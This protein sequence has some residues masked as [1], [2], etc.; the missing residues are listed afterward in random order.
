MKEK[1]REVIARELENRLDFDSFLKNT[2]D[3]LRKLPEILASAV[4]EEIERSKVHGKNC[5]CP[6]CLDVIYDNLVDFNS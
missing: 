5:F 4:A 1:I 6:V 3:T 2:Q